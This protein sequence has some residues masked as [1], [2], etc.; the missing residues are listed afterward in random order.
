MNVSHVQPLDRVAET[1]SAY[2]VRK[3]PR[4]RASRRASL[5]IAIKWSCYEWMVNT[6]P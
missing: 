1:A 5:D 3:Q 2:Q 6:G 4:M